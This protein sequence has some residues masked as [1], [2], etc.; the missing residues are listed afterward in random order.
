[1]SVSGAARDLHAR[2]LTLDAHLDVPTH[3]ARPGWSFGDRH[4]PATD[5][6]QVDLPRMAGNLDGG[7]FVI[8][9]NQG[10]LTPDGYAHA[11]QMALRR[12]AEIDAT[13]ARFPSRIGL[14]RTAEDALRLKAEGRRIAFKSIENCYPLGEELDLLSVFH[15]QGVRMAGPVHARTNQLADSST[16][17]PR[18]NG[19]SPLGER[20]VAEMNRLGMVIDASHASDAAFDRMLALS[21]TPLALSHSSPR[22]CFDHPRNLDD[23]RI[24]ALAAKGG[25]I[26]ASTIFL[27]PFN[28]GPER[29]AM[30]REIEG[31]GL[32]S[33]E[34]Q[35]NLTFRW[36]ALDRAEPMW[37]ADVDACMAALLHAIDVAGIDHVAFGADFDGGG[38]LP[39]LEDVT[40]LSRITERLLASGLSE[41]ELAKV[42]GGN[43]LR[44]FREAL[45]GAD[46]ERPEAAA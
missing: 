24:R 42:W 44:E 5:L 10:P 14:A 28:A 30:F 8:F 7:C 16:D 26:A 12:S 29:L 1:M 4:D 37:T 6:A 45:A 25:V 9:T 11:R 32:L 15:A 31:I 23:G 2:L 21:R 41:A 3:F 20:W 46:A 13:I 22:A 34:E 17:A 39:G 43:L 38:G 40:R 36:R 27:S 19:L 35:E 18:W 33:P